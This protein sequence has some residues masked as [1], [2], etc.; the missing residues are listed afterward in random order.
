[1]ANEKIIRGTITRLFFASPKFSAAKLLPEREDVTRGGEISIAGA[2]FAEK[3]EY[4]IVEGEWTTHERFGRQ[5]KV[6]RQIHEIGAISVGGL[7]G[8]LAAHLEAKGIGPVKAEA[9]A[10]EYKSDFTQ[11]LRDDPEQ[12]AIFA[13]LDI[14]DVRKLSESWFAHEERNVIGT[15]LAEFEL[16]PHQIHAIYDR[17]KGAAVKLLKE[18][19]YLLVGEVDGLG[20]KR[21]DGIAQKVGISET[22]PGRFAASLRHCLIE[23]QDAGSTCMGRENL[24][25]TAL[26]LLSYHGSDAQQRL[27]EAIAAAV[28]D[29]KIVPFEAPDGMY[30]ALPWNWTYERTIADFLATANRANPHFEHVEDIGAM[31]ARNSSL[32]IEGVHGSLD[33]SQQRAV[34]M[35]LSNRACLI[36][37]GAGAGKTTIISSI[38]RHYLARGLEVRL[39]APTGKASRRIEEIVGHEAETIHRMLKYNP[40]LGWPEIELDAD[41]VICDES[42]MIPAEL[43]YRLFRAI[44]R[45]TALVLVG[46]HHQLPPVGAGALLRDCIQHQLLPMAVLN[47]CHRQAGPLK[48]NCSAVLAGLVK[49]TEKGPEGALPWVVMGKFGQHQQ[50]L[51]YVESLFTRGLAEKLSVDPLRDVQFLSP[52]KKGPI[53]TRNLNLLLQRLHQ[54]RLEVEIE[55]EG[56]DAVPKLYVGDKVI[57]TRNNYKLEIMNGHQGYVVETDPLVVEF[58]AGRRVAIPKDAKDEIELAYALTIHKVQGSQYPVVVVVCH[59]SHY[60]MLHRNLLYTGCTRAMETCVIVGDEPGINRA[61]RTVQANERKTLLPV[62]AKR[63]MTATR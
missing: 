54:K 55:D 50:I 60:V 33:E 18:N 62:L 15:Q 17:F 51:E 63:E 53:G 19:P 2:F 61:V 39:C 29:K 48:R 20:F 35:A 32:E 21:V 3:Y 36:S 23:V 44:G 40:R 22:H 16:T 24:A 6:S 28:E 38:V 52:M 49:P 11:I 13:K 14:E 57:Q 12:I 58:A 10:R 1:M 8:W 47:Q 7:A 43:A 41:V 27:A 45:Q 30:Y 56:E 25:G 31:V 34:C 37:G 46:D 59:R 4:V 42:S 26:E 5:F 9:I